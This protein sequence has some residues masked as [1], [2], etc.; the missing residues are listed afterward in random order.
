MLLDCP[1]HGPI[2]H[3][4]RVEITTSS[5]QTEDFQLTRTLADVFDTDAVGDTA[6]QLT[7]TTLFHR[8]KEALAPSPMSPL[9]SALPTSANSDANRTIF[10][11]APTGNLLPP[12]D[13]PPN[14]PRKPRPEVSTAKPPSDRPHKETSERPVKV[15][16]GHSAKEAL[17]YTLLQASSFSLQQRSQRIK[18]TCPQ[19]PK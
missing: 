19:L 4:D 15:Q 16:V 12:P 9:R 14:R 6:A 2:P 18:K 11:R 8:L 13:R 5:E 3:K 10:Q 17:K 1:N 7:S